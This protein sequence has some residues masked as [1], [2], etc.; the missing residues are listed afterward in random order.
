MSCLHRREI[1]QACRAPGRK[2]SFLGRMDEIFG[3]RS[4]GNIKR[5]RFLL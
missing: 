2:V 3:M 1:S 4:W 5:K